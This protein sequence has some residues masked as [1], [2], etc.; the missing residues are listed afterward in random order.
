MGAVVVASRYV[1]RP[2]DSDVWSFWAPPRQRENVLNLVGGN[3]PFKPRWHIL[4][5]YDDAAPW[6]FKSQPVPAVF[7]LA[8]TAPF[9][10]RYW[11]FDYA[12]AAP[13]RFAPGPVNPV[14]RLVN[15]NFPFTPRFWDYNYDDAA[16]WRAAPMPVNPV[17]RLVQGNAPIEPTFWKYH[18]N[19]QGNVWTGK[20]TPPAAALQLVVTTPFTPR[21][22][23][24]DFDNAA[25]WRTVPRPVNP[26]IRLVNGNLPFTPRFAIFESGN[27]DRSLW[28]Y[29]AKPTSLQL[30]LQDV[31]IQG[32]TGYL[33]ATE[34][35][36]TARFV[37]ALAPADPG[38]LQ[39][40]WP[41]VI[42]R[43]RL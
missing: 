27:D 23:R 39:Y 36:D 21:F 38:D 24:Y 34:L 33:A 2:P 26:V 3:F 28:T 31:V 13:W 11:K 10:P 22:W 9:T 5:N 41:D 37:V 12:D 19:D 4:E 20:S 7:Q 14:L 16:P 18:Y 15:G 1:P 40:G 35:A 17:N 25:V 8:V 42:V 6:R 43:R 30:L 32:P 29:R